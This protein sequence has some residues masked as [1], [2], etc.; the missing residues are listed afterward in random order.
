[1]SDDDIMSLKMMTDKQRL[2]VIRLLNT[3]FV[4][5]LPTKEELLPFIV[6]RLIEQTLLHG[7]SAMCKF[8]SWGVKKLAI[9]AFNLFVNVSPFL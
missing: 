3:I 6:V 9:R 7:I 8:A 4:V 2:V 1:M 5:A